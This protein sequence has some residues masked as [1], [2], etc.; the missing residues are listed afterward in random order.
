M[1]GSLQ[2]QLGQLFAQGD[3]TSTPVLRTFKLSDREGKVDSDAVRARGDIAAVYGEVELEVSFVDVAACRPPCDG[4]LTVAL[5]R[6]KNLIAADS[7]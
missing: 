4:L 2:I 7:K 3:W 5:I 1:L 6:G